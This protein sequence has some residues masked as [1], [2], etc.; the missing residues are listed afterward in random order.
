MSERQWVGGWVG[1]ASR[2]IRVSS[3]LKHDSNEAVHQ[4]LLFAFVEGGR[5]GVVEQ[6]FD[7]SY[8]TRGAVERYQLRVEPADVYD[9]KENQS[10]VSQTTPASIKP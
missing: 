10:P 4:L 8:Q 7:A 6:F 1:K 3:M 5:R 2:V 9:K